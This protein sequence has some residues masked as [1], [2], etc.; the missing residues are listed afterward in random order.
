MQMTE[1]NK[2]LSPKLILQN[3]MFEKVN[4]IIYKTENLF[5]LCV[6]FLFLFS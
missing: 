6:K 3:F 2:T 4:G 1:R 5:Y